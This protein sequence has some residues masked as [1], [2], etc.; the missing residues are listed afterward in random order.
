MIDL[1]HGNLL[2]AQAEVLVNTVNCVGIMGKGIALQFKQAYPDNFRTYARACR[3]DEVQIGRMLV[4][5]VGGLLSGPRHI[6]NF[7]TK[8][9]WRA[10]SRLADIEAGLTTLVEEVRRLKIK[11]IA[12]PPLGCGNGGLDWADVRPRI[13]RAFEELPEVEV[14]L[15]APEGAPAAESMRVGTKRPAM[16]HGRAI[17]IA[18]ME[19][20]RGIGYRLTHL[21]IQK[22]AYLLQ[23]GG[24]S[25]RLNYEK[26]KFGP[27]AENLNHVL[28]AMEG[29]YTRGYG[30]RSRTAEVAVLPD[31]GDLAAK[32]LASRPESIARLGRVTRLIDGFETPFGMELLATVLWVAE[33]AD[34]AS[35]DAESIIGGVHAWNKRKRDLLTPRDIRIAWEH[36]KDEDWVV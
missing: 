8:N 7:P 13:E 34:G 22:L 2:D 36:L 31:A 25:L 17:L 12:V 23:V 30:D 15:F 24:E 18:V 26:G 29:H 20:Y 27:Y 1:R 6:I 16:T 32:A 14:L 19:R 28:Q 11:S 5:P 3:K 9:H 35:G 33:E 21:E 4:V 10:K